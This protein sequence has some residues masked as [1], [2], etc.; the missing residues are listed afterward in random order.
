MYVLSIIILILIFI[1]FIHQYKKDD[2]YLTRKNI[3]DI[4]D[5]DIDNDINNDIDKLLQDDTYLTRKH[6][7]D[8]AD[9]DINNDIDKLLQD[10]DH[11]KIQPNSI[12][13]SIPNTIHILK[14]ILDKLNTNVILLF[15]DH[16]TRSLDT[17]YNNRYLLADHNNVKHIFSENWYDKPHPKVTQIPIGISYKDI[18]IKN[19]HEKLNEIEHTMIDN[20]D[21]P[22][23][24]LCNSHKKTYYK[25]KSGY[26]DDRQIMINMLWDSSI[27]DFC[28]DIHD[29]SGKSIVN[30]WE[31]HKDYAFELSP[32][33]NGLDCHRTYEAIILNTIPIVRSNTLDPIYKEHDLP[34]VIVDE[35][36]EVTPEN[37][38]IWHNKYK[39]NFGN[40]TKNKMKINY[41]KELINSMK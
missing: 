24:V 39:H 1:I 9:Y 28:N 23:R 22:L 15:T 12:I 8:I 5:N 14:N 3:R 7:R 17:S 31:K 25:P 29:F 26:R 40:R 30:T 21:K 32:S 2:T 27:V 41:W 19:L 18:Y 38:Q 13:V 36:S 34:I 11:G 35:W 20:K 33:G 37:L 6:F 4:A 10:V 16:N